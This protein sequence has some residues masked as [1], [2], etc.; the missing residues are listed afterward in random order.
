[1]NPLNLGDRMRRFCRLLACVVLAGFCSGGGAAASPSTGTD[2]EVLALVQ[3]AVEGENLAI[4]SGAAS[5]LAKLGPQATPAVPVLVAALKSPMEQRRVSAAYAL[6]RLGPVAAASVDQLAASYA[7]SSRQLRFAIG[8]A[9]ADIHHATPASVAALV[10]E[11]SDPYDPGA[12]N[13]S[14][15][16]GG[17]G[18]RAVPSIRPCLRNPQP[19]VRAYAVNALQTIGPSATEAL[20]EAL[21]DNNSWVRTRALLS[22]A[23]FNPRTERVRLLLQAAKTDPD[24]DFRAMAEYVASQPR[25][26]MPD[27]KP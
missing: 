1:M 7:D 13:A 27:R 16:L 12:I 23:S 8:D 22:L 26:P 19:M 15:A 3:T 18:P 11:L 24:A 9:L 17:L 5:Q 6:E 4:R 10:K 20:A 14:N 25:P 2:A 21:R